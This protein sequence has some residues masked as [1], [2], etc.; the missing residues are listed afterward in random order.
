MNS[1]NILFHQFVVMKHHWKLLAELPGA[2]RGSGSK[3]DSHISA[4]STYLVHVACR[5]AS[6]LTT[7]RGN[8]LPQ[9]GNMLRLTLKPLCRAHS[10]VYG[11]VMPIQSILICMVSA[12]NTVGISLYSGRFWAISIASFRFQVLLD[13]LHPH[14][15]RA[16]SYSPRGK[17][18][19]SFG[20][21]LAFV[22]CG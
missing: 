16:S 3:F 11:F 21:L 18:L 13:S 22:Q 14:S 20:H 10:V 8:T 4:S 9:L 15:M 7:S 12:V 17:L 19:S 2:C 1:T 6:E 5:L